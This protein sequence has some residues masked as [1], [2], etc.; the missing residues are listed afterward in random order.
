MPIP[1]PMFRWP[2]AVLTALV[3]VGVPAASAAT[4]VETHTETA[5][6]ETL[7]RGVGCNA[8][9]TARTLTLPA[10]AFGVTVLAPRQGDELISST[11]N[12]PTATVQTV[13]VDDRTVTWT[14]V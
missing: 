13:S 4:K 1:S 14:A 2:A 10:K 7:F 11:S 3:A 12:D 6:R 8:A 9:T 5:A